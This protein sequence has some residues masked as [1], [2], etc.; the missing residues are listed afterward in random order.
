MK[1]PLAPA[2]L[3]ALLVAALADGEL[4]FTQHAYE[5]MAKDNLSELDVRNVLRGGA[6]RS[7]ELVQGTY[8]YRIETARLAV[9][10][11]VRG[12]TAVVVVTAWRSKEKRR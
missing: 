5:E 6:A 12:A 7:G 3:K 4:A 11:A 10:V 9:V 2:K 8:R 1:E